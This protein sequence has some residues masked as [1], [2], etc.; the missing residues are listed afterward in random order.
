M[1]E[2][3][4]RWRARIGSLKPISI[5]ALIFSIPSLIFAAG[6]LL[7]ALQHPKEPQP[8]TAE[9]L[10][11]GSIRED[12]YVTLEGYAMFEAG[13]EMLED[14]AVVATYYLLLDGATGHLIVV[15][16]SNIVI[17]DRESGWIT[18]VGMTKAAPTEIAN[19]IR[20]DMAYFKSEDFLTNPT[21]LVAENKSPKGIS[22]SLAWLICS[23]A[24]GVVAVVPFFFPSIVFAP[25]PPEWMTSAPQEKRGNAT[26]KASGRFLELKK[27]K[28]AIE[29]GKRRR[30]FTNAVANVIPLQKGR[31]MVYIQHGIRHNLIPVSKTHWGVL[32]D[33]KHA[34]AIE[35]GVLYGWKDRPAVRFRY[36][37]LEGSEEVLLLS[38]D[39]HSDQAYF[40]H[41]LKE[42]GFAVGSGI[43]SQA[44]V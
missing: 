43:S 17:D 44:I 13:Y 39:H 36:R 28:P 34:P 1:D 4:L 37:E 42:R 6:E 18:L 23:G 30:K 3:R 40:I 25:K 5:I 2:T 8:V 16:A 7:T 33:P 22:G 38:F 20:Q 31:L 41:F 9:Q 14:N 29:L 19:S 10:V 21:L 26:V 24:V 12:R 11:N 35:P 27:V 15:K 32:L